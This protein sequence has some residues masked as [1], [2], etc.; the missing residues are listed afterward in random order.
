MV[1]ISAIRFLVKCYS[2]LYCVPIPLHQQRLL[3]S[4]LIPTNFRF[5]LT[6]EPLE[7]EASNGRGSETSIFLSL[8]YSSHSMMFSTSIHLP[9]KFMT[10]SMNHRDHVFIT[11]L[12]VEGHFGY[13]HWLGMV[14][15]A[16]VNMAD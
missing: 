14:I 7:P 6:S 13:F 1:H 9:A 10:I 5:A 15:R 12:P 8:G 4:F 16:P 11:H 2:L 3:F